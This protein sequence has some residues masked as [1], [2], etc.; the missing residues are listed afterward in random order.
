[1]V[2]DRVTTFTLALKMG[3]L[4]NGSGLCYNVHLSMKDGDVNLLQIPN[5]Q[6]PREVSGGQMAVGE[7][8]GAERRAFERCP[9]FRL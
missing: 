2:E 9:L 7:R 5:V 3:T 1:M 6:I 4:I 8:R